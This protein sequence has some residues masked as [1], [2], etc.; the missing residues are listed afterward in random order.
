MRPCRCS[1]CRGQVLC[2]CRH[3]LICVCV[4]VCV[5]TTAASSSSLLAC[6]QRSPLAGRGSRLSQRTASNNSVT[7]VSFHAA[8]MQRNMPGLYRVSLPS[9]PAHGPGSM[10]LLHSRP[11]MAGGSGLMACQ[12]TGGLGF[13]P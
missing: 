10:R 5:Q 2:F 13:S 8:L 4:C 6:S 3:T 7:D 11:G 9:Y 1:T 12:E